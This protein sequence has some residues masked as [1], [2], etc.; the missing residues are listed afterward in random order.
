MERDIEKIPYIAHESSQTRLERIIHRLAIAL[1]V[2]V[3]LMFLSNALWLYA[4][5]NQGSNVNVQSEESISYIGKNG[6]IK[7]G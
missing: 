3:V 2:V 7:H 1:V 4:W 5:I 6:Y